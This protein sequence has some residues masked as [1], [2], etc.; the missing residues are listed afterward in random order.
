MT[1][2]ATASALTATPNVLPSGSTQDSTAT[3]SP[4]ESFTQILSDQSAPT[5]TATAT[6]TADSSPTTLNTD[7]TPTK[8]PSSS[9]LSSGE[10]APVS[11]VVRAN[12]TVLARTSGT[13][14][15]PEPSTAVDAS[16]PAPLPSIDAAVFAASSNAPTLTS[17]EQIPVGSNSSSPAASSD[18]TN[19]VAVASPVRAATSTLAPGARPDR[20][21]QRAVTSTTTARKE[22]GTSKPRESRMSLDA[23]A[24]GVQA[25]TTLPVNSVDTGRSAKPA[26]S[27]PDVA[28]SGPGEVTTSPGAARG[29]IT[30]S[31][32]RGA[33]TAG[34]SRVVPRVALS[35]TVASVEVPTVSVRASAPTRLEVAPSRVLDAAGQTLTH[36][37]TRTGD[38]AQATGDAAQATGEVPALSVPSAVSSAMT[39]NSGGTDSSTS[40]VVAP[41][42]GAHA[43]PDAGVVATNTPPVV[44]DT[45]SVAHLGSLTNRAVG[46][47]LLSPLSSAPVDAT[48]TSSGLDASSAV[49]SSMPTSA[50]SRS[51]ITS[52]RDGSGAT[53]E[54]T[55]TSTRTTS[56]TSM[57][58][59]A[60]TVGATVQ[61]HTGGEESFAQGVTSLGATSSTSG[62]GLAG[63]LAETRLA[64]LDVGG[65]SSAI[66]RPLSEGN[67]TYSVSLAMHPIELGHV[68]AV[69]TLSGTELQVTLSAH[70]EHGHSALT[71]A[72]N[73]LKN[74]LSR[75]GVNVTI[76]LRNPQSQTSDNGH[77]PRTTAPTNRQPVP[78]ATFAPAPTP[79]RDAGQI[80]L[81]L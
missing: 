62:H 77:R 56:L 72:M 67:G 49:S 40:A 19:I 10:A 32:P 27:P 11:D 44:G 18:V 13:P 76:D 4:K 14:A 23:G 66:S 51:S 15:T 22:L 12:D 5:A 6:A 38:T 2:V 26:V 80:H 60:G 64:N 75:G 74:E 81:M 55:S 71:V 33:S 8:T 46:A 69:M 17:S 47:P 63:A 37:A 58:T 31:V 68:Q 35:S 79:S 73:D 21:A 57:A 30:D 53:R 9:T 34:T 42:R 16:A 61:G 1:T 41:A 78:A 29:A 43:T 52:L 65:L 28:R 7:Q 39:G 70:T 48:P 25:V 24:Q 45:P 54:V 20:A 3:P 36:E 59:L 50:L